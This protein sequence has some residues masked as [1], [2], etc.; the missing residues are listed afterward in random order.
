VQPGRRVSRLCAECQLAG[1]G[2]HRA[3][4]IAVLLAAV[5]DIA[6][7][8]S[9]FEHCWVLQGDGVIQHPTG[10]LRVV[11]EGVSEG[12]HGTHAHGWDRDP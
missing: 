2:R 12:R 7:E 8:M 9:P 1:T 11:S 4:G 6:A 3:V 5:L 10:V